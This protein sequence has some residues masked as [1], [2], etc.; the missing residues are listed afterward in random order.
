VQFCVVE[1]EPVATTAGNEHKEICP[2]STVTHYVLET[3]GFRQ[4]ENL[5]KNV[6]TARFVRRLLNASVF[7]TEQNNSF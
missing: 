5:L 7:K 4:Q 6:S 3:T 1:V 2:V